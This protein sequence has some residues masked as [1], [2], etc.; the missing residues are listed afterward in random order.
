MKLIVAQ[1]R[2]GEISVPNF[3]QIGHDM[4]KVRVQVRLLFYVNYDYHW[5]NFLQNSWLHN[6]ILWRNPVL[7]F[8]KIYTRIWSP[9]QRKRHGLHTRHNFILRKC[10]GFRSLIKGLV[11]KFIGKRPNNMKMDI[12]ES[13]IKLGCGWN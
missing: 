5:D 7:S 11:R 1:L 6:E 13:F 2:Y 8:M 3:T 9:A 12:T 10:V 4:W